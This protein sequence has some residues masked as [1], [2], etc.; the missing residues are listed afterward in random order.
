MKEEEYK[1]MVDM[2]IQATLEKKLVW[3]ESSNSSNKYVA[4]IG[5]CS[6]TIWSDF[7]LAMEDSSYCMT[8][9]NPDGRVFSTYTFSEMTDSGEYHHLDKLF[10]AIRDMVYRI[11]ESEKRI[12]EGLQTL[13]GQDDAKLPF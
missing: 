9:A 8:F 5:G 2:L 13:L 4:I 11:T 10:N 12:M 1:N 3:T 6:V 7:D